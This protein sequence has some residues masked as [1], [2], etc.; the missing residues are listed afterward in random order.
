M[1]DTPKII[2]G[3]II[4]GLSHCGVK[5][6]ARS[7]KPAT[8]YAWLA[9]AP[10][11]SNASRVG[12]CALTK[13]TGFT[14]VIGIDGLSPQQT[15]FFALTFQKWK[16]PAQAFRPFKTFPQPGKPKSFQFVFG[17][18]F[19]P[20]LIQPGRTFERILQQ[21]PS[22]DF[23]LLEGDQIYAD[24]WRTNGL[25][26]AAHN[27][28]E[29][30]QAYLNVWSN[31]HHRELLARIPAF[32]TLDDHEVDNDWHW[33]NEA[34]TE[35]DIP[36]Y[37]RAI[38]W[39]TGRPRAERELTPERVREALQAYH[40]HQ[41]CHAPGL[42]LP[43]QQNDV[44][45]LVS[46]AAGSQAYSFYFGAAAFFVMDTRTQRVLNGKV[47]NIL[48]ETQWQALEDWLLAVRDLFP[49][50]FVCTS[51]ALLFEMLGDFADERWASIPHERDRFLHFLAAHGISGVY[52]LAGDLH[53]GHVISADLYGPNGRSIPIW[54]FSATPFE[55]IPN[56]AA[57]WLKIKPRSAA[58]HNAK[59]H[60]SIDRINYGL[61]T[62]N[63]DD[64]TRPAVRMDLHYEDNWV[65]KTRTTETSVLR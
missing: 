1:P 21:H 55:Q 54:E 26:F 37:T 18:C 65:W 58:L 19:L 48:G 9:S 56:F 12:K 61:V 59:V 15:Y 47:R 57:N 2:L 13:T 53:E 44:I 30:R 10:D 11:F 28:E 45:Q 36:F 33:H 25:G 20:G 17:S 3:P 24:D 62:V 46:R 38:R 34:F 32:M 7:D 23:I 52:L 49:V 4:G 29:Y 14:G 51:T 16:P 50:K 60:Y 31:P 22:L 6:W 40:E 27:L 5:L 35:A 64:P 63:F 42:T 41:A 43:A 8:L 39:L